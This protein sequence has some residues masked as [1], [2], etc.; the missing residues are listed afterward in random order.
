[1]SSQKQYWSS[2][3]ELY[4]TCGLSQP[5]FCKR[6]ELSF[7]Q[8][9]YRWYQHNLALKSKLVTPN[10]PPSNVFESVTIS[11]PSVK[12][13]QPS[14]VVE[15]A[16]LLPNQIRCEMKIDLYADEFS[17]LLKELVALC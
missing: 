8:F 17:T 5:E 15:L 14:N 2:I 10:H 7:N 3:I 9:Q 6:N 4:K 12:P 11:L 13:K 16:I 1:M